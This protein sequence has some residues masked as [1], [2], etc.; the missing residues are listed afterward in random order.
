MATNV[1]DLITVPEAAAIIGISRCQAWRHVRRG[2]LPAKLIGGH[3]LVERRDAKR[4]LRPK[5]G[6]PASS[7]KS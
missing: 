5:M 7:E 6:R 2:K 3:H 1:S 4:F